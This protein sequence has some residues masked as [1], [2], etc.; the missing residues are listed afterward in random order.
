MTRKTETEMKAYAAN[1]LCAGVKSRALEHKQQARVR[2]GDFPKGGVG[3]CQEHR[4]RLPASRK[5]HELA[6]YPY[7]IK[8]GEE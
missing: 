8:V 7:V 4:G 6:I 5:A 1:T 3:R 2:I